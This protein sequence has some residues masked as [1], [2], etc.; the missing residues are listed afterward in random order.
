MQH[1]RFLLPVARFWSLTLFLFS[2]C[3]DFLQNVKI[4]QNTQCV[5]ECWIEAW[6]LGAS[7]GAAL[8]WGVLARVPSS[9]SYGG[10]G[11]HY[12]K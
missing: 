8:R 12:E 10:G 5:E 2:Y 4:H 7:C 1:L 6:A 9:T 11:Q 3:L